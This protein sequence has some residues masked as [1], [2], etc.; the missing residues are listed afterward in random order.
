VTEFE[1]AKN[2]DLTRELIS[3]SGLDYKAFMKHVVMYFNARSY[4]EIGT[5]NGVSLS[6]MP[7]KSIAVDPCFAIDRPIMSGKSSCMLFQMTSDR[8]FAEYDLKALLGGPVEL[9]FLDGMHRYEYLLRDFSNVERHS[10]RNSI[11]CIHDCLPPTLE[12]TIRK[13]KGSSLSDKYRG[14][15]TGDVWKAVAILKAQ[16]PD[17]QFLFVDCPPTGLVVC[18]NLDPA[19]GLLVEEY[20][21]LASNMRLGESV[22]ELE[23]YLGS[24]AL[25]DSRTLVEDESLTK[26]IWL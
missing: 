23:K 7:C 15:W 14:Y 13:D 2:T 10:K 17:I 16:R 6:M 21:K 1:V 8:F 4:F 11:I 9:A 18:T 25:L 26:Y 24:Q 20:F 5:Q 22:F 12:M 3:H 19:N